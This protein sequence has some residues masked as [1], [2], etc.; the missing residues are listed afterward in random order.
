MQSTLDLKYLQ[1]MLHKVL[2]AIQVR[3]VESSILLSLA[4]GGYLLKNLWKPQ[5][6]PNVLGPPRKSVISGQCMLYIVAEAAT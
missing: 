3:Q 2:G 5:T 4:L 6:Y 1:S